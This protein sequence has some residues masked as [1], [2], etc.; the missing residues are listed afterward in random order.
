MLKNCHDCGV[1][2]GDLHGENCDVERCSVCGD[3][4]FIC[5]CEGHDKLFARWTGIWPG[6]AEAEYLGTDLN[7]FYE[8]GYHKM[9]FIKP[10]RLF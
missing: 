9:F 4:Y 5:G 3:Q 2:P 8:K 1:V 10:V 6:Q 7:G